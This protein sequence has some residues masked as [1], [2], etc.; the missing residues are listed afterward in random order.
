MVSSEFVKLEIN[1]QV[2]CKTM[3]IDETIYEDGMIKK[4][5]GPEIHL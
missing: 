3:R 5:S 2:M 4:N 1:I